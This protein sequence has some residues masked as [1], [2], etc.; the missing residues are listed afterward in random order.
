MRGETD[1]KKIN[2]FMA[3]LG[4]RV[5]TSGRVYFTG[6]VSAL[7]IGWRDMTVDID[8][9]FQPEPPGVFEVIPSLK[10]ELD[11][12]IEIAAPEDFIPALPGWEERSLYIGTHGRIL[13]YHYDFYSQALAKIERNHARDMVDVTEMLA[14]ELIQKDKL[15]ELFEEIES[16]LKRYPA[17]EPRA[18]RERVKE[19][20]G[21]G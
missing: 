4:R 15:L 7:L 6:G 12:N 14:R 1:K 9:K 16:E 3:E 10:D 18:F 19:D 20:S 5:G 17:I 8:C 11:M 13:F 2:R 21:G